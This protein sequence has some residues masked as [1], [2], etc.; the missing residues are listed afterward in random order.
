MKKDLYQVFLKRLSIGGLAQTIVLNLQ[1]QDGYNELPKSAAKRSYSI[2][3]DVLKEPMVYILL[4]CG[5]IYFIIGDRQ[6]AIMLLIFLF[7]II[8]ITIIQETKAERA[9]EALRDLSSPR[10]NVLRNDEKKRIAGRDVVLGDIIYLAEGD[11]VPADALV[12]S[13]NSLMSDESLLTGE[14]LPVEKQVETII[15]SGT[16]IIRGQGIAGVIGI[17]LNTEIGKIGKMIQ[18]EVSSTTSL[19]K[20]TNNLVKKTAWIAVSICVAV[21]VAYVNLH[22]DWMQGF[23]NGLSLAMAIMPNELPAVLAIFLALGAWRLSKRKVLTRNISA[24]E[25]LG[26]TTVLCVDKTGTLTLNQMTIQKIYS[27]NKEVNLSDN[28]IELDEEFH[29]ALEY[30]ILAS[31]M[32]PFD[33]MELAFLNAGTRFL[34]GTEHLHRD[35]LLKKEYPLSSEL[36]SITQAWKSSADG[37]LIIGAKGAP[38]AIIDLCH[39]SPSDSAYNLKIAENMASEGLRVIGI[40]KSFLD[41]VPLPARQ[42]DFD[43]IF[44]G[45]IGITDPVRDSVPSAIKECKRAGIRIVMITGDHP[46]TASNIAKKIGLENSD[47]VMTGTELDKYSEIE[48]QNVIKEVNV[49]SRIM[50]SQKLRLVNCLK[51]TGE[52]VAMTGDGV[53]DAPAL[54]SA[55]IGIAMGGRGTDV[56]REAADI[57]LLDDDFKS[58]VESIKMGRRIYA[59]LRSALIYLFA[60][61][62][63]IVGISIFPVFFNLP[64]ILFP[65]HIAFLHLII[66]PASSIA[67]EI[68]EA[69]PGIMSGPPRDKN[70]K[71]FDKGIWGP[72]CLMGGSILTALMLIYYFSLTKGQG[73]RDARTLVFTT[74]IISN[75]ALIFLSND[76]KLSFYQKI[77]LRFNKVVKVLVALS[78]IM[79]SFVLCISSFRAMF[80]FSVLHLDDLMICLVSGI[81]AVGLVQF[82]PRRS[83][84]IHNDKNN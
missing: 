55:D 38:E 47:K 49:F 61:H 81:C 44:V 28:L 48:L 19:E 35:W 57:V 43:F 56:A 12:I 63:P 36:L 3:L 80:N 8:G 31:R 1:K 76:S 5:L 52:I 32:D 71:L 60:V 15:Y 10:A 4:C 79:L 74:L 84:F 77:K 62:I 46:L 25:N 54:K 33:P 11:K 42:H 37:G 9:L 2:I 22:G 75:I 17:G 73:E 72:S 70:K 16:T 18:T 23:L 78:L 21:V 64:L 7:V 53:N 58:I 6:E 40:A 14:A 26:S 67:F 13:S 24:L 59:N 45:F 83:F 30:G 82:R 65:I 50:P 51:A 20:Q 66:E 34:Q 68:E 29:E 41:K 27:Q 39:L 69:A